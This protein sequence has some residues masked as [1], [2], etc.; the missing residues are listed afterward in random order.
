LFA[1]FA[2][3]K[4]VSRIFRGGDE[5]MT[6]YANQHNTLFGIL[7]GNIPAISHAIWG[8]LFGVIYEKFPYSS[9]SGSKTT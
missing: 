6:D 5:F 9:S 2:D 8:K 3:K 4:I 1:Y 7:Y